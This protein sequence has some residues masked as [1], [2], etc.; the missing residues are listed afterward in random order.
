MSCSYANI[1]LK[2]FFIHQNINQ[3]WDKELQ[4]DSLFS[5]TAGSII[6]DFAISGDEED[7]NAA[8]Q[9]IAELVKKKSTIRF[10]DSTLHLSPYMK[11]DGQYFNN[12]DGQ[13]FL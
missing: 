8:L 3:L 7:V 12:L 13:V 5:T 1:Q 9:N 6:V 10:G 2:L 11:V 4:I